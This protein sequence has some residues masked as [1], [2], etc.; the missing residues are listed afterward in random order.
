MVERGRQLRVAEG[1]QPPRLGSKE[2][3]NVDR[4]V[5]VLLNGH[6]APV[7]LVI[8][9]VG[10]AIRPGGQQADDAVTFVEEFGR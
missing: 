3:L 8:G 5:E 4:R 10:R 9:A 2:A 1:R 7:G 6:V